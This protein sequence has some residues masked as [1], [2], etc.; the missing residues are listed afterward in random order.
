V[1]AW[2]LTIRQG[3]DVERE[4][5][6]DLDT[7]L[8]EMKR[9]AEAMRREGNLEQVAALRDFAPGDRVHA[10]LEISGKGLLLPPTAGI[11][12]RGDGSMVAFR[13]SVRRQEIESKRDQTVF[14]AL[15]RAL[16]NGER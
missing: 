10:R 2:K 15:R 5:F 3:S 4:R 9:R 8:G 11:D 6:E 16:D 1:S 14:D 13:G 12:V 7:A